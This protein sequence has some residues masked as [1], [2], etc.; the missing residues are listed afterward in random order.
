MNSTLVAMRDAMPFGRVLHAGLLAGLLATGM[1]AGAGEPDGAC[2]VAAHLAHADFAMPHVAAALKQKQLDVVVIGTASSALAGSGGPSKAYP[3]R[4]EA[5]LAARFPGVAVKVKTY[6]RPRETAE[7]MQRGLVNLIAQDKP[8]LVIW[9]TGTADAIRGIDP[10][11]FRLA[12][13]EGVD[14]VLSAGIDLMFMNMQYS[15]RTESMI[16][17]GAYA[18]TMRFVALQHEVVLFDRNAIMK[19]WN[20]IG[21]FDLSA[22]TKKQDVAERVHNCIGQMLA[23]VIVESAKLTAPDNKDIH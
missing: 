18:D 11:D 13:E 20:E 8:A 23:D 14:A 1:P 2:Q 3:A 17:L 15:P 6:A 5:A 9:Q 21:T 16:A 10:A 7:E 22:A 19:Y 4:L 12:L